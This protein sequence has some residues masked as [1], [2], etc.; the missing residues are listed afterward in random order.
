[1]DDK[2]NPQATLAGLAQAVAQSAQEMSREN[3]ELIEKNKALV[4]FRKIDDI[5]LSKVTDLGQI[6]QQVVDTIVNELAF[7]AVVIL[8]LGKKD[9]SLIRL[10]ISRTDSITQ[11]EVKLNQKLF[12]EKIPLTEEGNLIV[13]A[14]KTQRMQITHGLNNTLTPHFSD[15]QSKLAAE[16]I[17]ITASFVYPLVVREEVIGAMLV[18]I[19]DAEGL[20]E[21]KNALID[22]L[23]GIIGVA[24]NNALLYQEI[25]GA[26]VRLKEVDKL[27]DEFVSIAS[28][29]LRT[30]LT[31]IDGLVSM[32]LDGEYGAVNQ[33]L[34]QPLED[35][36]T[37]SVR[38][39]HLVN[40]MLNLSRIKAGRMKYTLS[41][42]SIA[43][44]ITEVVH[45]LQPISEQKGLQLTAANLDPVTVQGDSDKVKEVLN[46]LIG[47]SLK[48]TDKG[49]ITVSTKA[50]EDKIEVDVTD[51][52][53]GIAKEDQQKLF[54]EFAQLESGKGRPPGTGLGLHI[55]R[56]IV[57][58]IGGDLWIKESDKGTRSTFAF[59]LPK[60][61]SALAMR[62]KEEIEKEAQNNPDQKSDT[63]K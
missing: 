8:L 50:D 12:G 42:F 45:L 14:V 24:I 15:E 39:I 3:K 25:Q 29:E 33:D 7:R 49:S 44:V 61:Q 32:I 43:D 54:G 55:S 20:S 48:F 52:G 13:K 2:V 23:A 19:N 31:A 26:N 40:D 36:N 6:A 28:H 21:F 37:S 59:S 62:V 53:I 34:K 9:N 57:R 60:S 1:M 11:A 17:G 38:L 58:K 56:E 63:I 47:N 10:V 27:K 4:L 35:V 41:E 51:T 5:I 18:S 16:T 22:R 30:P 46:N